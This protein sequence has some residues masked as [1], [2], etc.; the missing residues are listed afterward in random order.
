MAARYVTHGDLEQNKKNDSINFLKP[1]SLKV[2][3]G[4]IVL[5]DRFKSCLSLESIEELI[6]IYEQVSQRDT[7]S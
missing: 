5:D 4:V 1:S 2:Q 6:M 3:S 7:T